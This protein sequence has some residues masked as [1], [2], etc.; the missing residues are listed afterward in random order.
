MVPLLK[1]N[2]FHSNFFAVLVV[3]IWIQARNNKYIKFQLHR[4]SIS[5]TVYMH[6][7]LVVEIL[8]IYINLQCCDLVK[9][10]LYPKREVK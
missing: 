7:E 5:E 3:G 9:K 1:R 2:Y 6:F 10:N 8:C 4:K